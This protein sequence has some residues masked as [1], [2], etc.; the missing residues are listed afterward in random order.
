MIRLITGSADPRH[1]DLLEEHYRLRHEIFV[2]ERGWTALAQPD[3][4]EVD[5]YDTPHTVYVLAIDDGHVVGGYRF[6]PTCTPHLLQD[7]YSHLVDGPVPRGREIHEWSRFFIRKDRRGGKLFRQLIGSV[8]RA[9]QLLGIASLTS[10]IEPDWLSRF[11]AANFRYRLLGP[12]VETA[13]MQLAAV[14][15]NIQQASTS[16]E[17]IG[18]DADIGSRMGEAHD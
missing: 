8:P 9:C 3:R 5:A 12:F 18:W 14:Q 16:G 13:N 15:I 2:G 6:L 17:A 7:R 1:Q 4:R 11:D 10:V